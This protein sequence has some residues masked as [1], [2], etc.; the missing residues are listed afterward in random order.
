MARI[1]QRLDLTDSDKR[2]MVLGR[3]R[4]AK[5]ESIGRLSSCQACSLPRFT[6]FAGNCEPRLKRDQPH[7]GSEPKPPGNSKSSTVSSLLR[8]SSER[9]QTTFVEGSAT[10]L[11]AQ[12][13]SWQ[14]RRP[15]DWFNRRLLQLRV[16]LNYSVPPWHPLLLSQATTG[17]LAAKFR[18]PGDGRSAYIRPPP[19]VGPNTIG[20]PQLEGAL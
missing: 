20:K 9:I 19:G 15:P 12:T 5:V 18:G 11:A 7:A 13:L 3:V 1:R 4:R 6:P 16:L 10:S 8:S 14:S 17:A 2:V